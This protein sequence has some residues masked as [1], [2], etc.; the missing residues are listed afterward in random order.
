MNT[1]RVLRFVCIPFTTPFEMSST[2]EFS[3]AL[4]VT[5]FLSVMI[6]DIGVV[7]YRSVR[8]GLL[9]VSATG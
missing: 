2:T 9:S 8:S 7:E 3:F 4:T 5:T 1:K 6:I